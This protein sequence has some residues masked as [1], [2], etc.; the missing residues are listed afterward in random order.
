MIYEIA[1][2][3][4]KDQIMELK[5]ISI[6]IWI[7]SYDFIQLLKIICICRPFP[8]MYAIGQGVF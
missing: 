7:V 4:Y 2:L 1:K 6:M 5:L 3:G 8:T